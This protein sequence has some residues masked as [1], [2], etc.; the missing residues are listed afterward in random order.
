MNT[1][2]VRERLIIGIQAILWFIV[3][4]LFLLSAP[5][6]VQLPWWV[7]AVALLVSLLVGWVGWRLRRARKESPV[8]GA[9]SGML[10]NMLATALLLGAVIGFP[11]YYLSWRVEARP[12][13]MPLVHLSNGD[14]TVVFQGMVHVGS[15]NFYKGVIYDLESALTDGYKLFYE[16]VQPST[17]EANRWFSETLGHG[18]DLGDFYKSIADACG[19]HFQTD[20]FGPLTAQMKAHPEQHITA[21]VSTAMLQQEYQRLMKADPAFAAA[22]KKEKGSDAGQGDGIVRLL[23]WQQGASE[24]QQKL[25]GIVCRGA[26]SILLDPKVETQEHKP[27][28]SLILDYRN[29]ELVKKIREEPVKKIYITYGAKH[30]PGVIALLQQQDPQWKVESTKWTRAIGKPEHIKGEY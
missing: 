25:V 5:V 14:K 2:S 22:M 12:L 28:D 9:R 17:P 20:Y 15:E 3:V 10:R 18:G 21:D 13:A 29:V 4:V 1:L 30:I 16:G 6:L 26:F 24:G 11:I 27:I 19:L 7:N 23:K 8:A